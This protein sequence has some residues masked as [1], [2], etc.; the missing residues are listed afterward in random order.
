MNAVVIERNSGYVPNAAIHSVTAS[1][2]M[3]H[4]SGNVIR[5]YVQGSR[6]RA[7]AFLIRLI[8]GIGRR[9]ERRR[10]ADVERLSGPLSLDEAWTGAW[11]GRG[12]LLQEALF[13]NG[14]KTAGSPKPEPKDWDNRL[15]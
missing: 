2:E 3:E 9:L 8:E 12:R 11:Y 1:V 10:H 4:V 6:A 14:L 13:Q 15:D 5:T 7:Q